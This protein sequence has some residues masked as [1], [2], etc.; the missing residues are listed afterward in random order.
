[1]ASSSTKELELLRGTKENQKEPD[2][3]SSIDGNEQ[4][5]NVKTIASIPPQ[6]S[7]DDPSKGI[8]VN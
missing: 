7:S 2:L 8:V 4:L 6:T 5:S 1:V 3:C